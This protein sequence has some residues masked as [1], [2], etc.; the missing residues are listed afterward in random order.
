VYRKEVFTMRRITFSILVPD[1]AE[2]VNIIQK[3]GAA[4]YNLADKI[5]QPTPPGWPL[6]VKKAQVIEAVTVVMDDVVAE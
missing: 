6:F 2:A 4:M 1:K 5:E 3:M